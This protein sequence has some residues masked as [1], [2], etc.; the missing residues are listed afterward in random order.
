MIAVPFQDVRVSAAS[1]ES[2]IRAAF[3]VA[4]SVEKIFHPTSRSRAIPI[5]NTDFDDDVQE[6]C[7][8]KTW[9]WFQV[10]QT[11]SSLS[12]FGEHG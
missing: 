8:K 5:G 12:F 10:S 11:P 9:E 2:I 4:V 7:E 3:G 1:M 6:H